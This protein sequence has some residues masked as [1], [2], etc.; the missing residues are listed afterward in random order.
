MKLFRRLVV[1]A[2]C[3][4]SASSVHA[5][6]PGPVEDEVAANLKRMDRLDFDAYSQRKDLK[7]FRDM[8]C[9]DVKVVFADGRVTHG[10]EA[11]V[12]DIDRLFNGTPDSRISS[13]DIAFGSGEWTATAGF[14]EATFSEPM[15]LPD[16]KDILPT[17]KKVKVP[18]ATLARWKDGCI[19]QE[20]LFFDSA[21]YW[22][23]LGLTK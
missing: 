22:R 17:G 23:Q 1:T 18:I 9:A 16:G 7:L 13:H 5:T 19:I 8:H 14:V 2:A 20:H 6:E 10:V 3:L 4:Y 21:A 11:H 12:A 15:K